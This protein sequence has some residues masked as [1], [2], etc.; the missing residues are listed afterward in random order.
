MDGTVVLATWTP[1]TGHVVQLQHKN[2]LVSIYKHNAV[3]LKKMGEKVKAGEAIAIIGSSGSES[4][5]PHLHF[6]LW[7]KGDPIDP[8][9]FMAF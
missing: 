8:E 7:L 3:L 6:E 1:E 9:R 5:G 2:N 4:S